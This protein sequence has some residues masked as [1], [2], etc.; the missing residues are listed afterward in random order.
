MLNHDLRENLNLCFHNETI[1][2]K[3]IEPE[4]IFKKTLLFLL[5][6]RRHFVNRYLISV[7]LLMTHLTGGP[8]TPDTETIVNTWQ[9]WKKGR[10]THAHN[11]ISD[12]L[13]N[14]MFFFF[15]FL[16]IIYYVNG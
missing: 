16:N 12:S 2:K 15:F 5:I 10:T 1:K 8:E 3:K 14:L 11:S 13:I 9:T 4:E 7:T 6:S